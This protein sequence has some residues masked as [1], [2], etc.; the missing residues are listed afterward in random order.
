[1]S[2]RTNWGRAIAMAIWAIIGVIFGMG[3]AL[4][5]LSQIPAIFQY[6][7]T[8][9]TIWLTS[10]ELVRW[11]SPTFSEWAASPKQWLGIHSMLTSVPL[12]ASG[13]VLFGIPTWI[14][15]I[16]FRFYRDHD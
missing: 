2:I 12:G 11:W 4:C 1:M 9:T 15:I 6:F 13:I 16:A 8:G 3:L 5:E 10:L 7:Q 14:S